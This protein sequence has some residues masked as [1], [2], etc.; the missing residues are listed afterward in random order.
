M[1]TVNGVRTRRYHA[2]L[3]SATTPPTG[4][5]VMV[6]GFE[7][8][9][10]ADDWSCAIT[11]QRY[12]PD[13]VF[14]NGSTRI[15]DFSDQPW[16][17]WTYALPDGATLTQ[18]ILVEPESCE[19]IIWW[20]LS[21]GASL[22]RLRARPLIS[23]RDYHALHHENGSF[24]F[25][26]AV[27]GQTI[28]F[29]PYVGVPPI[30]FSCNGVFTAEAD[31]YRNF[32]YAEEAARGLDAQEDL[33]SP[34]QFIFNLAP[35]RPASMVLRATDAPI[36]GG[37]VAH[38][39]SKTEAERARRASVRSRL[40][41][42]AQSYIVRR[43]E[44]QTI[45]AGFPWFTDWGRDTFIAMRG[46]VLGTGDLARAEDIL[47]TWAPFVSQGMLPNRFPD[48]AVA[49][50]YNSVD[51]ALW[52]VVAAHDFL[53][54]SGD[55]GRLSPSTAALIQ[56]ACDAIL[57]GY[58]RGARFNIRAD[59]DG[60][61]QSGAP[62]LALTWMD[63]RVDGVPVTPR[64]G[65]P[66]EIQA[67]WINA[68]RAASRWSDKWSALDAR[69][70]KTFTERF[71]NPRGGLY[72]VIDVDHR[73]GDVDMKI[74]PNQILAVGGLPFPVLSGAAAQDV[75]TRVERALLTPLGLRTLATSE[76]AYVG[77]YR[78]GPA[79]RDSAYHQGSAWPWLLG[80][81][82]DAWLRVR[83]H[84]EAAKA[85]ARTRFLAPLQSHLNQA[86]LGHVSELAY[87]D[88]PFT[89]RGCPFQAWSLGEMIRIETMLGDTPPSPKSF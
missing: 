88:A 39:A 58:E 32:L 42:A 68:L 29:R 59:A 21:A 38:A 69:A 17:T 26:A 51:A 7:I 54:A 13:V 87:G 53:G 10:D 47:T 84:T 56:A 65:K 76:A 36:G 73:A 40:A 57:T 83:G 24:D 28:V 63:A 48:D 81:F 14:P 23:G 20:S 50:E 74:R 18:E 66:V 34:G 75:V 6:N 4:R 60:L 30:G 27:T 31:W 16:P 79:A 89:P 52:Y 33:A 44:G 49:P 11:S 9:V 78:G 85:E 3:L 41:R 64:T 12:A 55:A 22:R 8:W 86:G 82:V 61:L 43:D 67:L 45:L 25:S 15:Q 2:L 62:G 72:D 5:M 35:D 19:T 71:S 1:G 70:T 80:P 46:L 37:V 77:S